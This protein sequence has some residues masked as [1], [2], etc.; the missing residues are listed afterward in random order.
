LTLHIV[1]QK[2]HHWRWGQK[3]WGCSGGGDRNSG[4]VIGGGDTNSGDVLEVG[5]ETVG[6]LSGVG[7]ETVG[8]YW[9]WG[10]KQW[11]CSGGGDRHSGE[12]IGG[13]DTNSGDAS[14]LAQFDVSV[15]LSTVM[16]TLTVIQSVIGCWGWQITLYTDNR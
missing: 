14:G 15:H 4:E 16:R 5:T 11:G 10:Q 3:Q 9:R 7:T 6:K 1:Q 2:H 13:G 12:V 8:M